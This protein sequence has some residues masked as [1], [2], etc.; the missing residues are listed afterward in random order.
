MDK[1]F[2]AKD[3]SIKQALKVMDELLANT[4]FV[5]DES[6]LFA[7]VSEGDIRRALLKNIDLSLPISKIMN[8]D[9]ISVRS[10]CDSDLIREIFIDKK[11]SAI[12]IVDSQDRILN[13]I[14][15]RD[16]FEK[17]KKIYPEID[18]PVIVMAGGKGRRL[19]PFTNVFPKPL[20]PLGENAIIDVIMA[21]FAKYG[22]KK[23]IISVHYK[24]EMIKTYLKDVNKSYKI[25]YLEENTPL[26][27]VGALHMLKDKFSTPFFVSNCDILIRADYSD[28]FSFHKKGNYA[29]TLVASMQHH[30]VPYG[31]CNL[32][33]NGILRSISEKPEYDFLVNTGMYL[34]NPQVLNLIPFDQPFDMTDLIEITQKNGYDVAVYPISEKSWMD[35]GQWCEYKKGVERLDKFLTFD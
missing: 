35:I 28:I 31:V 19:E 25:E 18:L 5:V 6:R 14:L 24:A 32:N 30:V 9:P 10:D 21:E 7:S 3:I 15:R 8:C 1:Y 34:L 17:Q 22:M 23:F 2:V 4:V 13:I 16:F 26:G 29:L 33:G 27:T 20:M 12:P 11:I